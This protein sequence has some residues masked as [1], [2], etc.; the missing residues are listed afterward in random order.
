MIPVYSFRFGK[1]FS[2]EWF[3]KLTKKNKVQWVKENRMVKGCSYTNKEGVHTTKKVG[4]TISS[5]EFF[6]SKEEMLA[7]CEEGDSYED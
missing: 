1:D 6:S 2:P 3:V 5:E 4:D 7:Y